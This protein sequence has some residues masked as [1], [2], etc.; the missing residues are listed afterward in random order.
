[1][2]AGRQPRIA[3]QHQRDHA[4]DMRGRDRRAGG[5]LVAALRRRHQD[6]DAGRRDRDVLAAVGAGEQSCRRCRSP[7]PRSRWDRR[8]ETAAA[9]S[10]RHCRRPRSG[11]R[12]CRRPLD[13]ALE[14]RIVR[15]GEAHVDDARA[16]AH[17][18]VDALQDVE[19]GA[20]GGRAWWRRR[21]PRGGARRAR[22]RAAAGARRSRPPCRCRG[23]AASPAGPTALKRCAITPCSSGCAASISESITAMVTLLPGDAV[24]LGDSQLLTMYCA[25]SPAAR[26]ERRAI[27]QR[28]PS[29]GPRANKGRS[30]GCATATMLFRLQPRG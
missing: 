3:L 6:V 7:S 24:R 15:A 29:A 26:G 2:S 28:A 18:P 21:A 4:A 20:L 5:E 1:M 19:G 27:R 10:A 30:F 25:G 9:I 14:R 22:R 23:G 11:R 12:P 17:R 16:L 8:R 13:R